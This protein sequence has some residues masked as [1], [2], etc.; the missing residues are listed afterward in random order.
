MPLSFL[1]NKII[2]QHFFR[3]IT[4]LLRDI[5][6]RFLQITWSRLEYCSGN[7][8]AI[9]L[10]LATPLPYAEMHFHGRHL[11]DIRHTSIEK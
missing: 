4:V 6:V 8:K 3:L 7:D 9:M 1:R 2:L 10:R 5:A 11:G